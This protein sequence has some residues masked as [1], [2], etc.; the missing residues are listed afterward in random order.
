LNTDAPRDPNPSAP[1][2]PD[3]ARSASTKAKPPA[4]TA[5]AATQAER[6]AITGGWIATA[7]AVLGVIVV[8]WWSTFEHMWGRWFPAWQYE[9]LSLS[10]RLTEGDSYYTHGPLVPLVAAVVGFIIYKRVGWPTRRSGSATLLGGVLLVGAI[11][12]QIASV[13]A[14]VGFA[15]GFA[16]VGVLGGL[17]LVLGGWPLARCYALPVAVL[18]LM[19][20]PPMDWIAKINFQLKMLATDSAV[21]MTTSVFQI[22]AI[23]DGS[24]VSLQPAADGT[25]KTLVVDNVCGGLRSLIAL[26]FFGA[27]FAMVCRVRGGWRVF[28]LLMAVPVAVACNVLRITSLNMVAHYFS[29]DDAGPGSWFHDFTGFFVFIIALA[30]LFGLE[31]SI[32]FAGKLLGRRWTDPQMM[33]FLDGTP[34]VQGPLPRGPLA[35]SAA[36]LVLTAALSVSLA[37]QE[38][39]MHRGETASLGVS[40][41]LVIDNLSY[42]S[43][44]HKLSRKELIILETEDYLYRRYTHPDTESI[45]LIIV[46]SP[47]NRKGTHP[48]EVCLE[49]GGQR[50]VSK[51]VH[52]IPTPNMNDRESIRVRELITHQHTRSG[53]IETLHLYVYKCGD[54]YTPDFLTQQF[55]IFLNGVTS[56][57]ASGALIRWT[58]PIRETEE[59]ARELAIKAVAASIANVHEGLSNSSEI[60]PVASLDTP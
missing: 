1:A 28:L 10:K 59:Q 58:V 19:A 39:A 41:E 45:D 31:W 9:G 6:P 56:R 53:V 54:D 55:T 14:R 3:A 13:Y 38:V 27:L 40:R 11:F 20:P 16:M 26:T 7:L 48:P 47:D 25:P 37:G 33:G 49:G 5:S 12:L 24:I 4:S 29:V 50:V 30:L 21:W 42:A 35:V 44:D 32:L 57:D 36:A 17:L 18:L 51:R 23:S 2:T 8:G 46:F 52:T 43:T 34:R 60:G 22:P 15:S